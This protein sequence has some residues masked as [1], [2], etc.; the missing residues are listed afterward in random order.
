ML[1]LW[2]IRPFYVATPTVWPC[3]VATPTVHFCWPCLSP[4]NRGEP[5]DRDKYRID[6]GSHVL[7][8]LSVKISHVR[9]WLLRKSWSNFLLVQQSWTNFI[10]WCNKKLDQKLET[11]RD[12]VDD[13]AEEGID[14][15]RWT[16]MV[17]V[18]NVFLT[19]N[20]SCT[21]LS[22]SEVR[23]LVKW[24]WNYWGAFT[25]DIRWLTILPAFWEISEEQ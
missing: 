16:D 25:Q 10:C 14:N 15:I 20:Y 19:A 9:D 8:S 1:R 3:D 21:S 2:L 4:W 6:N 17:G 18:V 11:L 7:E 12:D 24:F 5:E 22:N 23:A 13:N